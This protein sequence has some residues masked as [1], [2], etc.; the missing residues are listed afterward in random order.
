VGGG[1]LRNAQKIE[2]I[3]NKNGLLKKE[4][5]I[6]AAIERNGIPEDMSIELMGHS[7]VIDRNR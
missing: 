1:G 4:E 3:E 7:R 5:E 6:G 2:R